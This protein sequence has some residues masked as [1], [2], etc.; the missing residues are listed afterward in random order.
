MFGRQRRGVIREGPVGESTH[1]H[2]TR[3]QSLS[4]FET[5]LS[6]TFTLHSVIR[7]DAR[8]KTKT[9]QQSPLA[10]IDWAVSDKNK[11]GGGVSSLR[12]RRN[13]GRKQL[14]WNESR[15]APF[16]LYYLL[17]NTMASE[18]RH[19]TAFSEYYLVH[20]WLKREGGKKTLCRAA[21]AITES[22][23]IGTA[24]PRRK[25]RANPCCFAL[26]LSLKRFELRLKEEKVSLVSSLRITRWK[27]RTRKHV[28]K[29]KHRYTKSLQKGEEGDTERW[30]GRETNRDDFD[31]SKL[32][33][34]VRLSTVKVKISCNSTKCSEK[35]K[36]LEYPYVSKAGE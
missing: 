7:K 24:E 11:G 29:E 30:K 32:R 17:R 13:W 23:S 27:T 19:L 28:P 4:S 35:V 20:H 16:R 31:K 12:K 26:T 10:I 14:C 2:K 36:R 5:H 3:L 34:R 22:G 8:K 9:N 25:Q 21:A 6:T 33:V 18:A 15:A 1:R